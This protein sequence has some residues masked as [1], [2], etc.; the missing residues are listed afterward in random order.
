MR[1]AAIVVG[2][3]A[4]LLVGAYWFGTGGPSRRA[5][6]EWLTGQPIAHRG[7]WTAGPDRPE[8][9]LAAFGEAAS[10]GFAVELDA[11][12]TADGHVVVFH[13][14]DLKRMTGATGAVSEKSLAELQDLRLLG[15]DE[16]I[17]T[18][19][20]VFALI[21]GR[22][23]V[24][25]EIKNPGKVGALEDT[26]AREVA[27]YDGE[28]TIMSFNPFS[29]AR[30]AAAEPEIPRGQVASALK[31][32]GRAFYEVFLLRYLLMN[33]ES[34]PDYIA[35]DL[36]ELPST[37]TKIQQ[38]RGRPLIGWAANSTKEREAAEEICDAVEFNPRAP[39]SE[40]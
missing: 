40:D 30:V 27:A 13:D 20:E 12:L 26:V 34:K 17:P 37:T 7:Q 6:A 39:T 32:S 35:Y 1:T 18:L 8:N 23:P 19:A 15:G 36:N 11:Q 10:N 5:P 28:A 22:V 33:W 14:G 9:S 16:T 21:D 25:V 31:D 29:M 24:F 3:I 2:I 4:L 38:W